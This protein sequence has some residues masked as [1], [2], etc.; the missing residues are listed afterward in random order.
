MRGRK[1]EMSVIVRTASRIL[2]CLI[3]GY[4]ILLILTGHVSPGGSF[5]GGVAI[6]MGVSLI[7]IGH[8]IKR[9]EKLLSPNKFYFTRAGGLLGYL[10]IGCIGLAFGRE[11]LTNLFPKLSGHLTMAGFLVPL[12]VASGLLVGGEIPLLI[13]Y[14]LERYPALEEE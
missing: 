9:S 14:Y 10:F 1:S 3:F 6:G 4:A 13:Y 8:G 5:A 11:F 2:A 7:I 12:L